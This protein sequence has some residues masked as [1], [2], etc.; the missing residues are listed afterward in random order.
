MD[1][2]K[3]YIEMCKK[4]IEIQKEWKPEEGDFTKDSSNDIFIVNGWSMDSFRKY[5]K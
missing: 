3:E 2:S 4:A 1:T 5:I